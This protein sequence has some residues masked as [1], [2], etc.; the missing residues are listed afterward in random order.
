MV[1]LFRKKHAIAENLKFD[2]NFLIETYISFDAM[3]GIVVP[4]LGDLR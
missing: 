3:N 1:S 4:R 2:L